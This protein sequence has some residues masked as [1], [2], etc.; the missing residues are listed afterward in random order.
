MATYTHTMKLMEG[1]LGDQD[2]DGI[3]FPSTRRARQIAPS[4]KNKMESSGFTLFELN[5]YPKKKGEREMERDNR[6][7]KR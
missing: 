3:A 1:L 5:N 4:R 6:E 7:R 2:I